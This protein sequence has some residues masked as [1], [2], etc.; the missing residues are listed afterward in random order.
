MDAAWDAYFTLGCLTIGPAGSAHRGAAWF[1]LITG[2][3]SAELN[4]C[5]LTAGAGVGDVDALVALL[6]DD[7]P[8]VVFRSELADPETTG[9]LERLGFETAGAQEA[10]MVCPRPPA[11]AAEPFAVRRANDDELGHGIRISSE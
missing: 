11:H 1:A 8:A 9:R 4:T 3:R 2:E 7:L 10:L 5:A 6:G